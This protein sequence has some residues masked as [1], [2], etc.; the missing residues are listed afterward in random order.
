M[1]LPRLESPPEQIMA[2]HLDTPVLREERSE[3]AGTITVSRRRVVGFYLIGAALAAILGVSCYV[4]TEEPSYLAAPAG[5]L[6]LAAME[7]F[8]LPL[9]GIRTRSIS[10]S[11][12]QSQ[13][14]IWLG[15]MLLVAVAFAA[16]DYFAFGQGWNDPLQFYH[17]FFFPP[18]LIVIITGVWLIDR[19][20]RKS[21]NP[22]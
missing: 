15:S 16:I 12:G 5:F 1:A 4:A 7:W 3:E 2:E 17:F 20:H 13:L 8:L 18:F 11:P 9:K 21:R 14:V 10:S 6:A 19:R 22:A